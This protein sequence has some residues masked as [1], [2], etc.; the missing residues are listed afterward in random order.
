[1]TDGTN[2]GGARLRTGQL[3][4]YGQFVIPLAII[5]LPIVIYI[6]AFYAGT[7]GLSLSAVGVI[8]MIARLSDVVTDPL[9][10]FLSDKTNTRFGR[11]RP[12]I[13]AG[14]P[15]L[16]ISSFMLFSPV[17]EVSNFYLLFWISAIYLAFTLI[18]I[19][20]FAWGA[21]ISSGYQE[22][23]RIT[24]V[25]EIFMQIGL[26]AAISIP[27]A[28]GIV[29]ETG[30]NAASDR[31]AM[32][33]LGMSTVILLPVGVIWL[34]SSL[35][36]PKRPAVQSVPFGKGLKIVLQNGP[37]RILLIASIFGALSASVGTGVAILFYEHVAGLGAE[38][39]LLIFV[40]FVCAIIGAPFWVFLGGRVS[41]HRALGF[42][43]AFNITAFA[44]VPFIILWLKPAAP[45]L[46]L[47]AMLG[48]AVV[49]GLT[50]GAGSILGLS[51]LADI[52]DL[53]M[54]RSGEP[55]AAFLVSFLGMVRKIFE[56]IGIG[57][58][59]PVLAWAGFD[60]KS[61]MHGQGGLDALLVVYCIV[62]LV[63]SFL[64]MLVIWNYPV[65]RARQQRLRA[66]LD[67]R[68]ARQ[69]LPPV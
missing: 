2:G 53:D 34:F 9:I 39:P 68:L 41:K 22:R 32:S 11:R 3:I 56:A 16:A 36:E 24:G 47:P 58:A 62:P 15:L 50:G 19:P 18:A 20:Y 37:F 1:M 27:L 65:S 12:W 13:V 8:L 44:F 30:D 67:K 45:E 6:P 57:L 33:W 54:L 5:G 69:G 46:V 23:S 28:Y 42:A 43:A 49:Q 31:G 55:R 29:N 63:L 60:P 35:G 48:V 21:E 25:R 17:G 64:S 26:L 52:G 66:A 61:E 14:A 51:I 38:A 7:L 59:L 10:G 40:M 4:G